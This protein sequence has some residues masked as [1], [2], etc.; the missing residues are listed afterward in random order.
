M[1]LVHEREWVAHFYPLLQSRGPHQNYVAVKRDWS[2]LAD[3]MK[4]LENNPT[5]ARRIAHE[6]TSFF[7]DR[8]LT[9]AA[10]AC[11]LRRM[12]TVYATVQN[13]E[14]QSHYLANPEDF[15][16]RSR[17]DAAPKAPPGPPLPLPKDAIKV[18]SP[19]TD[20]KEKEKKAGGQK[21]PR[22][23]DKKDPKEEPKK[24]PAV[25]RWKR[26]GVSFPYYL[27]PAPY[28]KFGFLATDK[29]RY[30]AEG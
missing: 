26:R 27:T 3:R 8:Y 16:D 13:F 17:K 2:D 21:Q 20:L 30:E 14:P 25:P 19:N 4:E 18:G 11:Y 5:R 15:E 12:I 22:K 24:E 1:P 23:E 7:R 10:E 28:S 29:A 9:P 6:V